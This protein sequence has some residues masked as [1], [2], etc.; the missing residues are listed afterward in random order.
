[1]RI[2]PGFK[3]INILE[4]KFHFGCGYPSSGGGG[5][6]IRSSIFVVE[7]MDKITVM[8]KSSVPLPDGICIE[9]G[10]DCNDFP[11][12]TVCTSLCAPGCTTL[13]DDVKCKFARVSIT[14]PVCDADLVVCAHAKSRY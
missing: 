5:S 11:D 10:R 8:V 1:M 9:Q 13:I 12:C 7:G 2:T 6:V 14:V 3:S 4:E